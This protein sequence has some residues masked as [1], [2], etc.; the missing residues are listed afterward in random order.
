MAVTQTQVS[1]AARMDRLPVFSLHRKLALILGLGTFFDIYDVF[2]GGI[3]GTVLGTLYNLNALEK[4]AVIGSGFFGMF[5]GAIV[6]SSLADHVGRR[7]M[8]MVNLFIYSLFSLAAAFAPNVLFV[9]IFRFLAG[10]GLGS[11]L[12][13]TDAYM[14]EML[15][16]QAR[17]RYT[18]WAY[19]VGFLGVPAS[20]FA[21]KFLVPTNFLIPGWRW[22]FILGSLGAL[23]IWFTRRNLPE[24]PRWLEIRN[25]TEA[26]NTAIESFEQAAMQELK[27]TQLAEPTTPASESESQKHSSFG[28][29]FRGVYTKRTTMLWIFQLFQTVGYYGFGSLASTILIAKGFNIVSTLGYT[30]LIYVGY[31]FGSLISIPIVE[32]MER[33]WLIVATAFLMAVFGLSFGFADSVPVLIVSGFLLTTMSN[34]FSNAY[35]I[36]QAEIFP[37]RIRGSAV[38]TAYSIS[39]LAS[40]ALPFIA[41]PILTTSGPTVFFIGSAIIMGLVCLDVWLLGPRSTGQSLENLAQ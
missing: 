29:M 20:G 23:I 30:A 2:L 22:L 19:T 12:P 10:I 28:E 11:E 3:I 5:V 27:L 31:P 16:K 41:L 1:I 8:Y 36:Y 35:H 34:V 15:P 18:A 39:R 7:T 26:A 24:S 32:R 40:A 25:R 38:G 9:V 21:G 6:M 4:A 37:T 17:G 14:G 33:K 13:L